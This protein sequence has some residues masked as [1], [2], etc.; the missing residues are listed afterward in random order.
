MSGRSVKQARRA[1]RPLSTAGLDQILT[2]LSR[3]SESLSQAE[4]VD[5]IAVLERIKGAAAA[6]QARETVALKDSRVKA[7]RAAGV[8]ARK[9]GLG[10][11]AEVALARRESPHQGSRLVGLADAL[12]H[13]M[14]H[15]MAA[16][17]QGRLSEWRA[18]LMVRE[19][20]CLSREHRAEVDARMSDRFSDLSDAGLVAEARRHAYQL[21][22]V[23][24]LKRGKQAETDRHV[25]GRA[26]PDTMSRVSALLPGKQGVA[27]IA[28]LTREADRRRATGDPRTKGQLMADT[29]VERVTG[30]AQADQTPV[31]IQLQ[32]TDRTLFGGG[33]EPGWLYG[34]GPVPVPSPELWS[35]IST[36][37]P[38]PGSAGSSPTRSRGCCPPSTPND[39]GSAA[40]CAAP[41]SFATGTAVPL[42]APP[43][44]DTLTMSSRW[45]TTATA[46][47]RTPKDS[48]KPATT[49]NKRLDGRPALDPAAPAS[50]SAS[51]RRPATPTSP[52]PTPARHEPAG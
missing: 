30:Q 21:D 5:R 32:V 33:S 38:R 25:S 11:G 26:A 6:A 12:V 7:E 31:E 46:P 43:R 4:R 44:C 24:F 20:A 34:Y 49:S 27:V 23:A 13:E 2:A 28:A 36:S 1:A 14:P 22:P 18:T 15:T 47:T 51:P 37:R 3:E 29:L 40:S 48:A 50:P 16:L 35:A 41:S 39:A 45:S 42:G 10:I 19:T 52:T 9:R 17:T 8:A